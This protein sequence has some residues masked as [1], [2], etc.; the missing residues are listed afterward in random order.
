VREWQRNETKLTEEYC[1]AITEAAGV[2][3][4][5]NHSSV[6]LDLYFS[7]TPLYIHRPLCSWR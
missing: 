3:P 1:W 4:A 6:C 2:H 5:A 7:V